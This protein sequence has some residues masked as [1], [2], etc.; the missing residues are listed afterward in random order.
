M[1]IY[2]DK[3]D[4]NILNPS[5]FDI[6][7]LFQVQHGQPPALACIPIQV[8]KVNCFPNLRLGATMHQ[9]IMI[10]YCWSDLQVPRRFSIVKITALLCITFGLIVIWLRIM[11]PVLNSYL[12]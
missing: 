6:S 11:S 2:Q 5:S 8:K 10:L 1:A 3:K 9:I 7:Y 4:T 12:R